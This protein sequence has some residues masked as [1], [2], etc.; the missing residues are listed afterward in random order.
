MVIDK[1]MAIICALLILAIGAFGWDAH[2][3]SRAAKER[4]KIE[5]KL[6]SIE[7]KLDQLPTT[8]KR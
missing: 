8:L 2:G 3:H 4:V 1:N 7:K 5:R 6:D